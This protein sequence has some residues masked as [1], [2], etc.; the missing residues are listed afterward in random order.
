M[1]IC[2]HHC[3]SAPSMVLSTQQELGKYLLHK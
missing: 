2:V 1:V 3:I